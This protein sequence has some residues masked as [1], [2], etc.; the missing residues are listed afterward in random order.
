MYL[1]SGYTASALDVL[2]FL[3]HSNRPYY[4]SEEVSKSFAISPH[5]IDRLLARI[6]QAG[7]AHDPYGKTGFYVIR[8][9]VDADSVY[10]FVMKI[11]PHLAF[12]SRNHYASDKLNAVV[13][14]YLLTIPL[15]SFMEGNY[16]YPVR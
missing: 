11:N 15:L 10:H 5:R 4:T 8:S 7:Y 12:P 16:E 3:Y 14:E 6:K 1:F 9:A 2:N 13:K